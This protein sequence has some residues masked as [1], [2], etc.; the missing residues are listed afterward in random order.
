[1]D[2]RHIVAIDL[3]T[4]KFAITVAK[5]E[6]ENIHILYYRETPSEGIRY[7]RVFNPDK[8]ARSLKSAI[9]S[10]EQEL[11]INITQVVVG[12]PKYE[13]RQETAQ[14]SS[15]RN[16]EECIT[17]SEIDNLK[18]MAIDTY[19]LENPESEQLFGAVAQSFSNGEEFQLVEDDIIGMASKIIE[20]NFK[21][22]IGRASSLNNIDVAFNKINLSIARKY[23]T[24]DST[25]KAVL[26]ESEMDNG[27]ALIDFG[28]GVTSLSIYAGNIMRHYAAIPFGGSTI[29]N[30]IRSECTISSAISENIKLAYGACM[31]EKLQSLKDKVL[32]INNNS[33][34][35][36]KQ[37]SVKYLS[38][39]ITARTKEIIE[40]MLYEIQR[41]GLADDLKSGIVIS[42]GCAE[43]ANCCSLIKEMSGY[44]VRVGYPKKIFSAS[45]YDGVYGSSAAVS[46]GMILAAKQEGNLNCL[47][48]TDKKADIANP[49]IENPENIDEGDKTESNSEI[50]TD[51]ENLSDNNLSGE[52]SQQE[53]NRPAEDGEGQDISHSDENREKTDENGTN[54]NQT[55]FGDEATETTDIKTSGG[56]SVKPTKNKKS[57]ITWIKEKVGNL[58]ESVYEEMGKDKI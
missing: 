23:F 51:A 25:A 4:S 36:V 8:V 32:Y 43:M 45:E 53:E 52:A 30:D 27:V 50:L 44:S 56:K 2:E 57:G 22:F 17:R 5:I 39:I 47:V 19:P 3:G 10:A 33:A 26:Y 24:P 49:F 1:M 16:P 34:T 20:G 38:E 21:L 28:A 40:A 37:L 54:K 35:P 29:T 58:F 42:G 15:T 11:G 6:G 14:M 7:S 41:S 13:I 9:E 55:L 18:E 46:I 31:P 48:S 12:K